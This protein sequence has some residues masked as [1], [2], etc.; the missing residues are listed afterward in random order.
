MPSFPCSIICCSIFSLSISLIFRISSIDP[1]IDFHPPVFSSIYLLDFTIFRH[2]VLLSVSLSARLFPSDV[3]PSIFYLYPIY[4]RSV[5]KLHTIKHAHASIFA[6]RFFIYNLV[7]MAVYVRSWQSAAV[8]TMWGPCEDNVGIMQVPCAWGQ[9]GGHV[10]TMS[11]PCGDH[12]RTMWGHAGTTGDHV[13]TM[14]D[15][16]GTMLGPCGGHVKTMWWPC[17]DHVR[18]MWRSCGDYVRNMWGTYYG[19]CG[20]YVGPC[21]AM[22]DHVKTKWKSLWD[23][24]GPMWGPCWDHEGP[25]G[26]LWGPRGDHLGIMWGPCVDHVGTMCSRESTVSGNYIACLARSSRFTLMQ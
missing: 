22:W 11:G 6:T 23:H 20:D 17:E 3:C 12:V 21:G 15:H 19:P 18:T 26:G 8:G 25:C 24:E 5:Y 4:S 13:G 2:S 7:Y 10:V 9:C 1:F 14:R 16:V